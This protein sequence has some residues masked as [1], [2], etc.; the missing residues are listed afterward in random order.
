MMNLARPL[1]V[2]YAYTLYDILAYGLDSISYNGD[3]PGASP[4]SPATNLITRNVFNV[5][6]MFIPS[7]SDIPSKY[8]D[9]NHHSLFQLVVERYWNEF[10]F[11]SEEEMLDNNQILT[12]ADILKKTRMFI[13]KFLNILTFTWQKYTAIL[14]AYDT[15]KTKLLD[16]LE[17]VSS[18]SDLRRDNDTPQDTGDFSDD[19]H[20]SFITQGT[21]DVTESHDDTSLIERLDK[22]QRLYKNTMLEW[23]NEFHVLFIDGGNYHEI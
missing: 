1:K 4:I 6:Q 17:R 21:T 15:A 3:Y 10:V 19:T 8:V 13:S 23:V 20:T 16:K 5:Y 14:G 2:K 11:E 9:E 22:I 18:G 12:Y 7:T